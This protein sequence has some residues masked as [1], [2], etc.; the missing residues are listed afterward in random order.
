M[1]QDLLLMP[2]NSDK[3]IS[4]KL[5]II[6]SKVL[7]NGL[8]AWACHKSSYFSRRMSFLLLLNW[9]QI[10]VVSSAF[11]IIFLIKRL[12]EL[13]LNKYIERG[14]C[15]CL[16]LH[17]MVLPFFEPPSTF[18]VPFWVPV[19]FE[20]TFLF[21]Y[22]CRLMHAK[23]F[24]YN[25]DFFGVKKNILQGSVIIVIRLCI[26]VLSKLRLLDFVIEAHRNRLGPVHVFQKTSI[27]TC[28]SCA[29]FHE[30]DIQ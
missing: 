10:L 25:R 2:K 30:L 22:S 18:E 24:Q 20:F 1:L 7:L 16:F 4:S 8:S 23:L 19:L 27:H 14:L 12:Y 9:K 26:S 11:L 5:N 13:Y 17:L 21:I 29:I 28:S 6:W 3:S 15:F